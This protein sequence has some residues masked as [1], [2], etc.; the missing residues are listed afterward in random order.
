MTYIQLSYSDLILPALLVVM[1]GVLSLVLRLKLE[2]QLAIATLRMVIQLVLVG[3][4]LTFLFAAVSP[5]WT[6]LAALTMVLFASR[7]IIA[8]QKRRLPGI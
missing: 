1:D 2:K 3:Y 6:A 4:V 8:R 7:E 5:L